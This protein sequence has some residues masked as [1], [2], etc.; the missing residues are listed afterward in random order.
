MTPSRRPL[1]VVAESDEGMV[2][3]TAP[4]A[5]LR[6]DGR[7]PACGRRRI[8]RPPKEKTP[9]G[10]PGFCG[11]TIEQGEMRSTVSS[12][13]HHVDPLRPPPG[14]DVQKLPHPA[15]PPE[16]PAAVGPPV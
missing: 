4:S 9:A 14:V 15:V 12:W 8:N 7:R 6:R 1:V 11:S 2:G 16:D 5:R 10:E 13:K 3:S